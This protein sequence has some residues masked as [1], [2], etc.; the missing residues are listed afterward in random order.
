VIDLR[1]EQEQNAPDL[2]RVNCEYVSNETDERDLHD[3]K[4][5]EQTV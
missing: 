1:E 3:E 5:S 4:Q 2:M